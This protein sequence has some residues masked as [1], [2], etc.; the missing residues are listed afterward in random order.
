MNCRV[1]LLPEACANASRRAAR[2]NVW[3]VTVLIASLLGAGT[4]GVLQAADRAVGR[5]HAELAELQARRLELERS[6]ASAGAY[7][8]QLAAQARAL[9][10]LRHRHPLP[11]QL[12]TL[13]RL[14]PAGILLEELRGGALAA[15]GSFAAPGM[16]AEPLRAA[17]ELPPGLVQMSGYATSHD[18][19]ARFIAAV[20]R[21]PNWERVEL[22]RAARRPERAGDALVFQLQCQPR[23]D[24][25]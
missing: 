10:S 17:A 24:I 6:L 8:N 20:Q 3:T 5:L 15:S 22:L 14:A 18:E 13:S 9:A 25:R 21:V 1:N 12:L 23:G 2:R 16:P 11:A 7:R 4:W 19:L